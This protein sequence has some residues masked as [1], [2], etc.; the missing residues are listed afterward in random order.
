DYA[1]QIAQG[2]VAAHD[3]RIVH[4][5]L[6]PENIFITTDGRIKILDFG[7]AKLASPETSGEHSVDTM[8]TQTKAGSVLCT[9]A[10]MSPEQLRGKA[11]DHRSDIFSFGSILYEMLTG[12]RAFS[13]ETEVDTMTAVLKE[14]PREMTRLRQDIP[15]AFEQIVRHCQEKEPENRFQ[16]ARD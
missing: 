4:R 6:K 1:L 15:P 11:V 14:E 12:K 3:K 13:G 5:D 8:T 2:L 9:R 7:I 16:S 10:Y